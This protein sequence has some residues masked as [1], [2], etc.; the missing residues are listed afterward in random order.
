MSLTYSEQPELGYTAPEFSLPDVVTGDT[1]TF[2]DCAGD[3]GTVVMFICNHCPYVVHIKDSVVNLAREYEQRGIGFVAISSNNVES[4]PQDGPEHMRRFAQQNSFGFPY[5]YDKTQ[6]VAKAYRAACTP[7]LYLFDGDGLCVYQGRY[8]A[9]TPGNGVEVSGQ[10]LKNALE[11]LLEDGSTLK[12][13]KPSMG[14]NIK[15]IPGNE[16]DYFG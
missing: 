6:A 3:M 16:P 5:L 10:D 13:Q 11:L 4:H 8:D 15:W 9:S 12:E 7:D 2:D 14:C 1:K